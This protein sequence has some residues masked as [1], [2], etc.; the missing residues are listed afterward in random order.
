MFAWLVQNSWFCV[1][2][3][4]GLLRVSSGTSTDVYGIEN[5]ERSLTFPTDNGPRQGGAPHHMSLQTT[6]SVSHPTAEMHHS[7]DPL[8]APTTHLSR[9]SSSGN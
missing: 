3:A 2:V 9:F 7:S 8:S 4:L 1:H 5:R 6:R